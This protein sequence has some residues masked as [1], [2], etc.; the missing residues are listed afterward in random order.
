ML[1]KYRQFLLHFRP[2]GYSCISNTI[3]YINTIN[4]LTKRAHL[5]WIT[6]TTKPPSKHKHHFKRTHHIPIESPHT[7]TR[8][9]YI[10]VEYIALPWTLS[11]NCSTK[12]AVSLL[13]TLYV[14][15]SL[16]FCKTHIT[17]NGS[18]SGCKCST[19]SYHSRIR[20]ICSLRYNGHKVGG[21]LCV[22]FFSSFSHRIEFR[23]WNNCKWTKP[24]RL[25]WR[26]DIYKT[27]LL[28]YM[29]A[30]IFLPIV[31]DKCLKIFN[32]IAH[33]GV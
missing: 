24:T 23:A 10:S 20:F 1:C 3:K 6:Q 21:K 33:F 2:S 5:N 7:M 27:I 29:A 19:V 13:N 11:F 25:L 26:R 14:G 30:Y 28:V 16:W 12:Q 8:S 22:F 32:S 9:H 15:S 18:C 17:E 31:S 4:I